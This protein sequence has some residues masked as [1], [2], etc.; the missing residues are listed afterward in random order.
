MFENTQNLE[1]TYIF[2]LKIGDRTYKVDTQWLLN[3]KTGLTDRLSDLELEDSLQRVAGYLHTFSSAYECVNRERS[4][5]ELEYEIWYEK[6]FSITEETIIKE[7]QNEINAGLRSKSNS[8][9]TKGNVHTRLVVEYE[10]DYRERTSKLN[11]LKE[12]A[13]YLFRE[14]KLIESRGTHLQTLIKSRQA[15]RS[16]EA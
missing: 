16:V 15:V 6:L 2:D 3:L 8:T 4:R 14:L 13:E 7:Y 12:D 1:D 10:G 11:E 5:E 9:P